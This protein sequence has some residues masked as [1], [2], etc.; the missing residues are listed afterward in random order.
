MERNKKSTIR[1]VKVNAVPDILTVKQ[2]SAITGT[3]INAIYSMTKQQSTRTKEAFLD[4]CFPFPDSHDD[5]HTGPVFIVRNKKTEDY[6]KKSLKR[7][8]K[9]KSQVKPKYS[10]LKKSKEDITEFIKEKFIDHLGRAV[11]FDA[12]TSAMALKA[13]KKY[14]KEGIEI[15]IKNIESSVHSKNNYKLITLN[16]F[17]REIHRWS[18]INDDE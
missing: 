11:N 4:I 3:S 6:I 16:F 13:E 10:E 17:F 1:K 5:L 8:G 14:G 7:K 9:G 2:L 18:Q 15:A 12:P